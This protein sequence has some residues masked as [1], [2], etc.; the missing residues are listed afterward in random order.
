MDNFPHHRN[1][2]C[3]YLN[4]DEKTFSDSFGSKPSAKTISF[5]N[6]LKLTFNHPPSTFRPTSNNSKL[7]CEWECKCLVNVPFT[8][9]FSWWPVLMRLPWVLEIFALIEL[10]NLFMKLKRKRESVHV[11]LVHI[12]YTFL[13]KYFMLQIIWWKTL[14]HGNR[15]SYR[16]Q[17]ISFC[18]CALNALVKWNGMEWNEI[19]NVRFIHFRYESAFWVASNYNHSATVPRSVHKNTKTTFPLP[20]NLFWLKIQN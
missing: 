9:N 5:I 12:T 14:P 6:E 3:L 13:K 11:H 10:Y 4:T 17:M 15:A 19:R 18:L 8:S 1:G 16:F 7:L 20:E 2:I